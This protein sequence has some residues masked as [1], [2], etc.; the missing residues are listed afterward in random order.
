M[1]IKICPPFQTAKLLEGEWKL[2]CEH[3]KKKHQKWKLNRTGI[4]AGESDYTFILH[5]CKY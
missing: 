1:Y 2:R 3:K 5:L 4:I